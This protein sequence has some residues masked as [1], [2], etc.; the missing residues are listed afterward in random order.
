MLVLGKPS[1]LG[2]V[3]LLGSDVKKAGKAQCTWSALGSDE[4][5]FSDGGLPG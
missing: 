4:S 5:T 2:S 3:G 1:G